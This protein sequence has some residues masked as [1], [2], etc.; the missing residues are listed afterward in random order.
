MRERP[1]DQ[2]S[3]LYTLPARGMWLVGSTPGSTTGGLV[4]YDRAA[5]LR[6]LSS[7]WHVFDGK[8]W[9][10]AAGI[11]VTVVEPGGKKKAV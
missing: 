9:A 3:F 8:T 5:R 11:R 10:Q 7:P 6:D 4:S 2:D 1:A